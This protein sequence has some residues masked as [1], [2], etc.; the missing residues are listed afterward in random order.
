MENNYFEEFE[1]MNTKT[2]IMMNYT[3]EISENQSYVSYTF[4]SNVNAP[5][6]KRALRGI[7]DPLYGVS[8]AIKTSPLVTTTFLSASS[9]VV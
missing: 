6:F 2:S 9:V 3:K 5:L 4:T 7:M 8:N 1:A